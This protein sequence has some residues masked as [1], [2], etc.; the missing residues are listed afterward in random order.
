MI[1]NFCIAGQPEEIVE[2]LHELE[3]QGLNGINFIAPL[4]QQYRL[5]EDFSEKIMARM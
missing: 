5:I 4:K 2:Q 1:R 3:R